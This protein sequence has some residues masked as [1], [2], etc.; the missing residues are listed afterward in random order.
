LSLGGNLAIY[1]CDGLNKI[2][3]LELSVFTDFR[4]C[5]KNMVSGLRRINTSTTDTYG[6]YSTW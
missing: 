1:Y 6:P 2:N 3:T 4:Y 5:I